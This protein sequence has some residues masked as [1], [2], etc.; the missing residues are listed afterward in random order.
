MFLS[1]TMLEDIRLPD[2]DYLDSTYFA[3]GEDIELFL[4]AQ[5][6][7]WKCLFQ[8]IIVGWHVGSASVGERRLIKKPDSLQ[9]HA[10]KNRFFTI[11]TCYPLCLLVW[12]LP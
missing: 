1:R 10:I 4:R 7:G 5:L 11:L 12:T 8:P 2:G 3:Y 9:A 6:T